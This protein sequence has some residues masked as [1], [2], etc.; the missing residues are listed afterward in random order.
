[1]PLRRGIFVAGLIGAVVLALIYAFARLAI[2]LSLLEKPME[3]M[4]DR[5]TWLDRKRSAIRHYG[6]RH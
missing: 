4:I 6:F 5:K 1:M 2:E 3:R